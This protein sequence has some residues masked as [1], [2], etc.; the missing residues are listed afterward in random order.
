[1]AETGKTSV[2]NYWTLVNSGLNPENLHNKGSIQEAGE[3]ASHQ[4]GLENIPSL[5]YGGSG[6][7]PLYEAPEICQKTRTSIFAIYLLYYRPFLYRAEKRTSV[8]LFCT[9][10]GPC[11]SLLTARDQSQWKDIRKGLEAL[12]QVLNRLFTL[13]SR[14][15]LWARDLCCSRCRVYWLLRGQ[16]P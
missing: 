8:K 16:T 3:R 12:F 2:K 14:A 13:F 5:L 7:R 6:P 15:G 1:M 9:P 10:I 4:E 11:S